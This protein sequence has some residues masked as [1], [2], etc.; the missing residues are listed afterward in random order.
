VTSDATQAEPVTEETAQETE[1]LREQVT[2]ARVVLWDFDGPICRLFARHKAERVAAEGGLV[3]RND[4][5]LPSGLWVAHCSDPQG[6]A[7]ALQGKRAQGPK[8]GWST[9]W[10]GISSRGRMVAAKPRPKS[11]N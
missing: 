4:E 11:K 6:A 7:F 1:R 9:E 8:V 3:S 2:R 5:E 10:Q